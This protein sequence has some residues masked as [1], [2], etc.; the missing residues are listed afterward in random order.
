MSDYRLYFLDP[1]EHIKGVREIEAADDATA[2]IVAEQQAKGRSFELWR[3][4]HLVQRRW[5]ASAD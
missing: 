4:D 1:A 3:R 2:S 5:L